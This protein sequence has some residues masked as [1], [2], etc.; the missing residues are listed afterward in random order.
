MG[1]GADVAEE[2]EESMILALINRISL[3][4]SAISHCFPQICI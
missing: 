1:F 4:V 2:F 3:Y